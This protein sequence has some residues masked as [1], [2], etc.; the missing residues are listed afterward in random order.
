MRWLDK[1]PD[2]ER[3]RLL[4]AQAYQRKD[5]RTAAIK[6]YELIAKNNPN[7]AVALNNLAWLYHQTNDAR[8]LK[9]A[10][11]AHQLQPHAGAITDTYGWLLVQGGEI[12]GGVTLLR[13]ASQQAPNNAEIRYHLAVGLA[14]SG[15]K[16][17]ARKTLTELLEANPTFKQRAKA[18]QLLNKL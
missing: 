8:A 17:E 4:L 9:V 1:H 15:A 7:N 2:D 16:E 18:E 13:E 5:A 10:E 11:Q 6:Q 12:K 14:K 3:I